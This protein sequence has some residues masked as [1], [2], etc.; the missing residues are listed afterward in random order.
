M[1]FKVFFTLLIILSFGTFGFQLFFRDSVV[2]LFYGYDPKIIGTDAFEAYEAVRRTYEFRTI[3]FYTALAINILCVAVSIFAIAR[4][5]FT[6][7]YITYLVLVLSLLI[8][9][10]HGIAFT[11]PRRSF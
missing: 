8:V 1:N 6:K 3:L 9:A 2:Y 11:I 4:R 5:V 7:Y 10:F